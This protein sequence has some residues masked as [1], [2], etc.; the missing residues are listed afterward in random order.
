MHSSAN[1]AFVY[2]ISFIYITSCFMEKLFLEHDGIGIIGNH[3]FIL[4]AE[5]SSGKFAQLAAKSKPIF[6]LKDT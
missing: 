5:I 4:R 3:R 1:H 2:G 6:I